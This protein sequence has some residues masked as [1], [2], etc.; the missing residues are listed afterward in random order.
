[1]SWFDTIQRST[2]KAGYWFR[3]TTC[4]RANVK[5]YTGIP[6]DRERVFLV[7]ASKAHFRHNPFR[8]LA[9]IRTRLVHRQPS[10]TI[11]IRVP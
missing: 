11:A 7:G 6:Q 8:P 4:W 3:R 5:D 1:M 9:G 2:R 10:V